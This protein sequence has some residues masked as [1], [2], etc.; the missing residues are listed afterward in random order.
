MLARFGGIVLVYVASLC[1]S[2]EQIRINFALPS[3][4]MQPG[5]V[6][7]ALLLVLNSYLPIL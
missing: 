2:C 5:G 1:S 4:R 6:S 3:S 7:D